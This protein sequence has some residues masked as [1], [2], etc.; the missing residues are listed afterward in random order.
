MSTVVDKLE[1]VGYGTDKGHLLQAGSSIRQHT[2]T[3]THTHTQTAINI[4]HQVLLS[5]D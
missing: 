4:H 5:V 1:T 3:H 2:Q